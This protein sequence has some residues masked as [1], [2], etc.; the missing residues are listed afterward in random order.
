MTF[1]RFL[2][3][4]SLIVWL[5]GLIFFVAT[6]P[7]LFAVLPTKHLAGSV[8]NRSLGVLHWMG[9]ISGVVFLAC[10]MLY[11]RLAGTRVFGTRQ[12]L[13]CLMLALTLVSQFGIMPKMAGLRA[14]MGEI[15]SVPATDPARMQFD[16]LHHWSTRLEGSVLLLGL[17]VVYLTA[18]S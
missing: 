11:A 9:I 18:S 6:A 12:A 13:L 10:S 5:G 7:T 17:V 3:L 2:M 8:V 16:A 15:D 14:S 4:L 1:L